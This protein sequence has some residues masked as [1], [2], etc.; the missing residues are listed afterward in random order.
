MNKAVLKIEDVK[1][2][3]DEAVGIAVDGHEAIAELGELFDAIRAAAHNDEGL[4]RLA[5]V[6]MFVA[7][8]SAKAIADR[9]KCFKLEN[10]IE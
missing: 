2:S 6:G 9:T 7:N 4:R 10:Q 5:S 8:E 3:F 1:E